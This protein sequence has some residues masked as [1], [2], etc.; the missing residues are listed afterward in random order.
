LKIR[1]RKP[2]Q[3]GLGH[4]LNPDDPDDHGHNWIEREWERI[5]TSTGEA[6]PWHDR[7]A[8]SRSTISSPHLVRALT[9]F[10]TG[11][12]YA[13][14]IKPFGFHLIAHPAS[15]ERNATNRLHL[16]APYSTQPKKWHQQR[17]IDVHGARTHRIST[18]LRNT[19]AVRARTYG[20]VLAEYATHPEYK[21]TLWGATPR[22]A[23]G[24]L[25]RRPV[26]VHKI[27]YIGKESNMME[28]AEV[29][30]VDEIDAPVTEYRRSARELW[31]REVRPWLLTQPR[32]AIA[33]A[34]GVNEKQV[35]R[36]RTN[37][38]QPRSSQVH[39]LRAMMVPE[40]T[41]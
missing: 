38:A 3:H 28:G 25:Q 14:Q 30:L 32:K 36:W 13:D 39:R 21:S 23:R 41:K 27:I 6:L 34:L 20:E 19:T 1:L 11:K 33:R 5:V 8:V 9:A 12:V 17:W 29:G 26:R 7:P 4:L 22:L 16:I 24:L 40:A 35:Q 15:F 37:A 18:R 31:E 10:N 2:S